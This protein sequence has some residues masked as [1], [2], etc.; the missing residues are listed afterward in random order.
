[1]FA[2]K[3]IIS[4]FAAKVSVKKKGLRWNESD[5]PSNKSDY[6]S[7]FETI[8][9]QNSTHIN[10]IKNENSAWSITLASNEGPVSYWRSIYHYSFTNFE[11]A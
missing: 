6:E 7:F 4:N 11:N 1:M 9:I 5:E 8:N 10:Q 3:R 2:I